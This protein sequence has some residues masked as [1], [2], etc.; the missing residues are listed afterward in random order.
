[1][2]LVVGPNGAAV[3]G[4]TVEA[5]G[6]R[7]LYDVAFRPETDEAWVTT[8]GPDTFDPYG[9]DTLVKADVTGDPAD[10]GFPGCLYG[11]E[12]TEVVVVDNPSGG[13][14]ACGP[15]TPPDQL[16]GLHVSADGLAF[17]PDDGFWDGDLFIAEFGN[18]FGDQ[19]VGH[20]VVR[21]GIEPDGTSSPP[22]DFIV[23]ATPL[24][25]DFGPAGLYVADFATGQITLYAAP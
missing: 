10:F 1:R 25:L 15:H 9:E 17:G 8:N 23:G 20:R 22:E 11:R 19:V 14:G 21:V 6:M 2:G 18:F 13:P 12:G 5:T 24:D 3:P 7:N 16:L 4:L